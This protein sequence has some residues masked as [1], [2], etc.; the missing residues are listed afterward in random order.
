MSKK[1]LSMLLAL[2]MVL[3]LAACGSSEPAEEPATEEPAAEKPAEEKPA[4]E[5]AEEPAAETPEEPA[6]AFTVGL[7]TDVGGIDDKSFNQGTWEGI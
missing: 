3:S 4:E 6:E 5:P 7:V 2:V 1:F